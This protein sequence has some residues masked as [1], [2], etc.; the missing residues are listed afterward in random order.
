M[1]PS[2]YI[3]IEAIVYLVRPFMFY[4][5]QSKQCLYIWEFRTEKSTLYMEGEREKRENKN[6][7]QLSIN[8]I[9]TLRWLSMR[10]DIIALD[11]IYL[12]DFM[13]NT[14]YFKRIIFVFSMKLN[15]RER[16][17][18]SEN[19]RLRGRVPLRTISFI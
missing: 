17:R 3:I 5:P 14:T 13:L 11:D 9:D 2:N 7:H 12:M 18:K 15:N 8:T 19:E 4:K 6:S 10:C 1:P 16:E